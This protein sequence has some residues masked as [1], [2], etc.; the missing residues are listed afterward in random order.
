MPGR[1]TAGI[2]RSSQGRNVAISWIA[3]SRWGRGTCTQGITALSTTDVSSTTARAWLSDL[4][5]VDGLAAALP[6]G[7][8]LAIAQDVAAPP[9]RFVR[10]DE[11]PFRVSRL[12]P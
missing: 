1:G 4:H 6:S 8:P 5:S 12:A 9:A 7:G 3:F 10:L 2:F 11:L